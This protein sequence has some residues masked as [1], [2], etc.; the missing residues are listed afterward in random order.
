MIEIVRM[1][2]ENGRC[3]IRQRRIDEDRRTPD[4]V[5]IHQA[6]E[7]GHQLLRALDRE[8]GD[9]QWSAGVLGGLHAS[10]RLSSRAASV[11]SMRSRSP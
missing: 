1:L 8:G 5:G 2:A 6:H 11:M 9:Q 3:L 7:I 10:A 4:P